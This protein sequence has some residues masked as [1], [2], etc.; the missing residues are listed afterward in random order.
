MMAVL[1]TTVLTSGI[2][3]ILYI[4]LSFRVSL[5]RNKTKV[6]IG[7]GAGKPGA[8]ALLVAVRV[9]GNFGEYVPLALILLGG[10]EFAGVSHLLCEVFAV[11]LVLSRI[12]HAVGL[13]K[14]APNVLR[15]GGAMLTWLVILGMSVEA[16]R[17]VL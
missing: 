4:V 15:A 9:Q 10:I 3:G 12:M 17:L 16:I 13:H 8:E 7:D 1:P 2:L 5:E 14:P 11:L 6:S